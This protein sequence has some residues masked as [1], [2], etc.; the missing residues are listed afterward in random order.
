MTKRSINEKE[1][2]R[3]YVT[4]DRSSGYRHI[5]TLLSYAHSQGTGKGIQHIGDAWYV[6]FLE[7][8]IPGGRRG[9]IPGGMLAH[10]HYYA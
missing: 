5:V 8:C 1:S 9:C 6:G 2:C 7:G 3:G 10:R 4:H